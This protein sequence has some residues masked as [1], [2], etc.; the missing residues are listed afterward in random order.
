ME[1]GTYRLPE[2]QHLA[3]W[4]SALGSSSLTNTYGKELPFAFPQWTGPSRGGAVLRLDRFFKLDLLRTTGVRRGVRVV[5]VVPGVLGQHGVAIVGRGL[6]G[7]VGV[8]EAARS[9]FRQVG[10]AQLGRC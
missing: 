10:A 5:A 2:Q 9:A 6:A 4:K 1:R 7:L 3:W 8:V